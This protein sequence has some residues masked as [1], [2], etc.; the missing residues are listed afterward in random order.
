MAKAK[1]PG[2]PKR[3]R[4][5]KLRTQRLIENNNKVLQRYAKEI[6]SNQLLDS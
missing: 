4:K 3:S 2:K 5:S 6:N 1:K